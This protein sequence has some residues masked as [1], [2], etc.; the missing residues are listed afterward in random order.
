M[1]YTEYHTPNRNLTSNYIFI[2]FI[3][4]VNLLLKMVKD[5]SA[6]GLKFQCDRNY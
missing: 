5:P 3:H 4:K 2:T 6:L 1:S